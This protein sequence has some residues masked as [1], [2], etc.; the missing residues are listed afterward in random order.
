MSIG[1]KEFLDN[2][3]NF[4]GTVKTIF[5]AIGFGADINLEEDFGSKIINFLI[6]KR[7]EIDELF[8]Q[9]RNIIIPTY[10]NRITAIEESYYY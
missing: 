5:L 1:K 10:I 7:T 4:I 3:N 6:E 9:K 8:D 2:I